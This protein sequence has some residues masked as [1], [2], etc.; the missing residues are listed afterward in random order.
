[1]REQVE[2]QKH[3]HEQWMRRAIDFAR[4]G[5]GLTRPNPPVGAVIVRDGRVVGEGCHRKA[6]GPHAEIE[7][8]RSAKGKSLAGSTL[9][10]TLEPCSTWGRTAPCTDAIRASGIRTVVIGTRDPN[11]AHCGRGIR[12]LRRC[13]IRVVEHV[14]EAEA[15]ELIE[16][17]A[18]WVIKKRPLVTLK[19]GMSLDGRIADCDGC[20]RWITGPLSRSRVQELRRRV[21]GILVGRGTVRVDDPSL[22]PRPARGRR[23]LRIVVATG[24]GIPPNSQVLTD[25]YADRTIVA[26]GKRCPQRTVERLE[27]T[28]AQVL[29]LRVEN[30]RV[31]LIDLLKRLGEMGLLHVECEGGGV[32]AEALIRVGLV[33][34]YALFV[35]PTIIGGERAKGAVD[36]RGWSLLEAPRVE[37]CSVERVGRDLLIHAR[38]R[39]G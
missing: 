10:V 13:G 6:G 9:Y 21:D 22:L 5:E 29:K 34:H 30:G 33:D 24:G 35:A 23:P 20:S 2:A 26:V 11:P 15:R 27:L 16:P 31:S 17:F 28:G 39:K 38:P 14:C 18:S 25:R 19:L 3:A 4:K 36:G 8:L 32:L 37:I 7:A 1:M 12:L